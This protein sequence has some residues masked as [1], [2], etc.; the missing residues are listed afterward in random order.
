M[1]Y[2]LIVLGGGPAGYL[3]CERAGHEGLKVLLIEKETIGGVC[4]NRGCIPTKTLLYS[5][6]IKDSAEHGEKYGVIAEKVTIDHKAVIKRKNKVVKKLTGGV[7]NQVKGA[8]TEIVEG[9]GVIK[10]QN[11]DGFQVAV[12][13]ETYTGKR[14]LIATGSSPVVPPI[15]GVKES[16]EAGFVLTSREMLDLMEVPEKLVV[17]GGG[18]IGLEMASYFNSVGSD[19]TVIEMLPKIGGAIDS[20]IAKILQKEY[21]AKGVKFNLNCMV[22]K[23]LGGKVTY[24]ASGE[25]VEIDADKVLLSVGRRPNS[26]GIGL[27]AIGVQVE[28]GRV[29]IDERCQTNVANV[30]CAGDVNGRSM[31]AHTAYR[32]SEVA[33]NN[34]V[35]KRDVMSYD[36]IPGVIYTNPE[37]AGLGH[38]KESAKEAGLDVTEKVITM[39]YAGR[40]MAEN[41]RG[42]GIIKILV[43]NEK[44]TLCGVHMIG[45]YSSEIIISAGMMI[46]KQMSIDEIKK[47]VFPH[48]TVSEVIREAIFQL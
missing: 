7:K 40:Y 23:V 36:A 22:T 44:N 37:V 14:L 5:A 11:A 27:E 47:F 34:M 16:F 26:Q 35:G 12:G 31:L 13:E 15:D 20:D 30:Y 29:V 48:P 3:A 32:H 1:V 41:E 18:V 33:V 42:E 19:V 45:N 9:E 6:K 21:E 17:I 8:G 24:D 28:R 10:G 2:D 25:K 4:L 39:N 38:T 43:D 46:E